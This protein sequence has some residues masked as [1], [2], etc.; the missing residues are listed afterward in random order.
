MEAIRDLTWMQHR[1]Y[2]TTIENF[3]WRDYRAVSLSIPATDKRHLNQYVLRILFFERGANRPCIAVNC[4]HSIL[5]SYCLTLQFAADHSIFKHLDEPLSYGE[6]KA[7]ALKK[8]AERL[9]SAPPEIIAPL[10][11]RKAPRG[12][13]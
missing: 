4:E 9:A 7:V 10:K 5:E 13:P 11:R 6:F 8:V 1:L 2:G 3:E 12:R